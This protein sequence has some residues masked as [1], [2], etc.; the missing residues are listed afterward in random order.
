MEGYVDLGLFSEAFKCMRSLSSELTITG[1]VEL[2]VNGVMKMSNSMRPSCLS[3]ARDAG[4]PLDVDQILF[5]AHLRYQAGD[6]RAALEWLTLVETL[7]VGSATFHHLLA[8]CHAGLGD[9]EQQRGPLKKAA[10]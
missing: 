6:L 9:S 2:F 3:E 4:A 5:V 10:L 8:R 1:D 7:C